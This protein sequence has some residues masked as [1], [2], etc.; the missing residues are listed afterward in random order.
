[1]EHLF[2]FKLSHNPLKVDGSDLQILETFVI[3]MYDRS[4]AAG[5]VDEA[6]LDM[7]ARKQGAYKAIPSTRDSLLQH[8]KRAAYQAGCVWD[9][10]TH[11]QSATA[12]ESC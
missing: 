2:I 6:R 10:A 1:M 11:N 12:R 7:F 3:L 9:R 5:T 4:S 8:T